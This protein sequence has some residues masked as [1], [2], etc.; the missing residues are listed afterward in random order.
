MELIQPFEFE[1]FITAPWIDGGWESSIWI[2]IMGILVNAAC[3]LVGNFL[4]LRKMAL[5]GD[6]IS[7]SLLPGIAIV[8]LLS[9]SRST[10]LMVAGALA[11]GLVSV[12]LIE[13]IHKKTRVKE[14]AALGVTFTTLFAIGVILISVFADHVDLDLECVLYGEIGFIYFDDS[15]PLLGLDVPWPVLQM[16]GALLL[17]TVLL[18]SFY[19]ELLVTSFDSGLATSLGISVSW[20]HYGLMMVLSL[21]IVFSFESVGAIL[22]IAML[23]M[24]GVTS[25]LLSERLPS[26]LL[27]SVLFAAMYSI[28]GLHIATWLDCSPAGAMV[29]CGFLIFC[30]VW[31][32]SPKRGLILLWIK[33]LRAKGQLESPSLP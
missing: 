5:V 29:V 13:F 4:I 8:F 9:N 17:V 7:H 32:V 27:L 23:I 10:G 1:S 21:V 15:L 31:L 33:K 22:V 11:A 30:F 26:I 2:V 16:A 25:A 14:D 19:K 6:A 12:W 28:G 3:G 18:L 24:P 20:A